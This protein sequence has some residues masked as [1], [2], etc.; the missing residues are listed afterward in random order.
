MLPS[1]SC[2]CVL[3]RKLWTL[4]YVTWRLFHSDT[5]PQFIPSPLFCYI[6]HNI[7]IRFRHWSSRATPG[8]PASYY[9]KNQSLYRPW[10]FQEVETPIFQDSRH[11]KMV[12]L[13]ALGTGR[14]YA[15][16]DTLVLI[17]VRGCVDPRAIVRPKGLCQWKIN[18][19][20]ICLMAEG[21]L[22]K[23]W[24]QRVTRRDVRYVPRKTR[25]LVLSFYRTTT[26]RWQSWCWHHFILYENSAPS[27][28]FIFRF[29]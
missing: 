6:I 26:Y 25:F 11:K 20:C 17:S 27:W 9:I 10:G 12:R 5:F 2:T 1:S 19:T 18:L 29:P 3:L 8:T 22:V 4:S 15:P 14:L 16:G 7:A 21:L 28:L 13:S 23:T 24:R